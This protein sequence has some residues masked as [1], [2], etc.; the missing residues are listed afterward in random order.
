MLLDL[1]HQSQDLLGGIT[2]SLVLLPRNMAFGLLIFL[3]FGPEYAPLGIAAGVMSLLVAN[4]L[5][6]VL[7]SVPIMTVSTFSLS[8]LIMMSMNQYLVET[9]PSAGFADPVP[10]AIIFC[11]IATLFAGFFQMS[12]GV[13]RMGNLAKYI[14]Y[15]VLSGLLNGTGIAIIL[16]QIEVIVSNQSYIDYNNVTYATIAV[17][18]AT[19]AVCVIGPK[20]IKQIPSVFFGL[21][22]GSLMFH[23]V[24]QYFIQESMGDVVGK[25]PSHLPMPKY[26]DDFYGV[27]QN[28]QLLEILGTVILFSIAIGAADT[29]RAALSCL[30]V[31]LKTKVRSDFNQELISEG[32]GNMIAAFFG[33]ITSTGNAT[34]ALA[35]HQAGGKTSLSRLITGISVLIILMFLGFIFEELPLSV[36]AAVMIV[37]T[38]TIMDFEFTKDIKRLLSK[39]LQGRTQIG[40]NLVLELIVA[41]LVV[42]VDLLIA[43]TFGLGLSIGLFVLNM[44]K[45]IVRTIYEGSQLPSNVVRV[46]AEEAF[47]EE[48]SKQIRVLELEG[49]LFFGTADKLHDHIDPLLKKDVEV[50]ILDMAL[51]TQTDQTAIDILLQ[52]DEKCRD[53]GRVFALSSM[54]RKRATLRFPVLLPYTIGGQLRCFDKTSDA[55]E[56][57]QHRVL[58]LALGNSFQDH[59]V[60]LKDVDV[61]SH[62]SEVDFELLQQHLKFHSYEKGDYL[63]RE[64][65]DDSEL[66]LITKGEAMIGSNASNEGFFRYGTI[67]AGTVVGEMSLFDDSLR[68]AD[69]IATTQVSCYSLTAHE[70]KKLRLLHPQT[71]YEFLVG[72]NLVNSNRLRNANSMIENLR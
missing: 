30:I 41:L 9:L 27:F 54:S 25:L 26:A 45:R 33:S 71:A 53:A 5:S 57:A 21:I 37:M 31:D 58:S 15:P 40:V 14:P 46:R 13:L 36:L 32:L 68:S 19:I 50:I 10:M 34:G 44:S 17:A 24:D 52:C 60:E 72:L 29:M 7:A 49:V 42:T 22:L 66:Y 47:L 70:L 69:V 62:L 43:L 51:V 4:L 6:G 11:F 67:R 56:W 16:T 64:R 20:L 1:K 35:N 2:A 28:G 39:E 55:L 48:R 65:M 61:L 3:P 8:A 12:F 63:I 18:F 59:E 38:V 23:G